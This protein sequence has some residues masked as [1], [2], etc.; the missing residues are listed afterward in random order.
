ME[1]SDFLHKVQCQIRDEAD[2][3][4]GMPG[5]GVAF[6]ELVFTDV[7][8]RH[9][10]EAGLTFA[11]QVC[12]Y[13]AKVE[14]GAV[15]LSGY[16]LSADTEQLDLYVSVYRGE[17]TPVAVDDRDVLDAGAQCARFLRLCVQGT[18]SDSVD[19]SHDAYAL[20]QTLGLAFPSIARI[21][22]Y[23]LT[24]GLSAAPEMPNFTI[25]DRVVVTE[26]I[27]I[28]YL[29]HVLEDDRL[30]DDF[31]LLAGFR[32]D[33]VSAARAGAALRHESVA[34]VFAE[35][36]GARLADAEEIPDFQRCLF[37]FDDLH[38]RQLRVDGYAFDDADASL[39]L[40]VADFSDAD[41]LQ[42]MSEA[43]IRAVFAT[44]RSYIEAVFD[45]SLIRTDLGARNAGIGLALDISARRAD[46]ARLRLY[47]A[48]DR[49][50]GPCDISA[51][52]AIGSIPAEMHLWDVARFHKAFTSE[53]GKDHFEVDFRSA[54]RGL[55]ALH[56]GS[57]CGEYE[58]YLCTISGDVLAAVYEQYGSRLLEGNVRSFL[59]I[60]GKINSGIQT[61]IQDKPAMFFAYNNGIAATADEVVLEDGDIL[62]ITLARNFQIVNGGQTTASLA[63]A[64]R[65]GADLSAVVVQ[66][67]LSV[68]PPKRAGELIPLIAR[69]AN[70]QNKVNE[71][72]FFA[73]HPYHARLEQ[74]SK[75]ITMPAAET[76][77]LETVWFYERF[78]GQYVN[79]Q[80]YLDRQA[81]NAFLLIH[82]KHQLLT[83]LDVARL[84]N[85]WKGLPHK[86]STGAQKN[87]IYFAGW[88]GKAWT[89]NDSQFDERYF[90]SLAAM[91]MLY[92]HTEVLVAQQPWYQGAY[93]PNIVTYTL[94]LLQFIVLQKGKGRQLDLNQI[95]MT[96]QVPD[97]LS[98][99]LAIISGAV[100]SVLTDPMRPKANVTEWAKA[101][102]CWNKARDAAPALGPIV[103]AVLEDP[104]TARARDAD[105]AI[106]DQVG[107][108]IF[109]STAV[110]GIEASAWADL[111]RWGG[112]QDL[113]NPME[114]KLLRSA[115]RLPRFAPSVPECEKIW[116]VRARLIRSGYGQEDEL[117]E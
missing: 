89:K 97:P 21:R 100:F 94:A 20:I 9:M 56:A 88:L 5:A 106:N 13:D 64:A 15:R 67:K 4:S 63:A 113:L 59:S 54:G 7:F 71:S 41:E 42:L 55:P 85:T 10:A 74:I 102:A 22:I 32:A 66:M 68:L 29:C 90:R 37:A 27:D 45:G 36:A 18:L 105:A 112:E 69:F 61:T 11:P 24:D 80:K 96:Q 70:S 28:A 43:D 6:A 87:F 2:T 79:E 99:L 50:A 14:E 52:F 65:A 46:T 72:D 33:L 31:Q 103:F 73:N 107:Y 30:R 75:R 38:G 86:V 26:V 95:W 83:K 25:A 19:E 104:A 53:S 57:A 81:K 17:D 76:G 23:V 110:K 44:L 3:L 111:L 93:R 91:A 39:A 77:G 109:A 117:N 48:T 114:V 92:R 51:E 8:T 12:H 78:R 40:I 16:A 49:L 35:D 1:V 60:K 62:R 116:S 58:G 82:P 84:E 101:E 108:G 34:S 98:D 115:T 47:L